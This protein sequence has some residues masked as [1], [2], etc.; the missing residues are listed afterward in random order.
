[1]R[2]VCLRSECAIYE[3]N[4]CCLECNIDCLGRCK[5]DDESLNLNECS[6]IMEIE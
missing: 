3:D 4:R 5:F 6:K 1:M 2:R